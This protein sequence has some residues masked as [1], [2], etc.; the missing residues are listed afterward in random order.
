MALE[1]ERERALFEVEGKLLI[2]LEI[3]GALRAPCPCPLGDAAHRP[4]HP[5]TRSIAAV[6]VRHSVSVLAKC[7]LPFAVRA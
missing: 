2:D 7:F 4:S 1:F 6:V 3:Y 5:S